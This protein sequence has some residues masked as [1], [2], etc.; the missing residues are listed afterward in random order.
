MEFDSNITNNIDTYENCI[1]KTCDISKELSEGEFIKILQELLS[2][3]QFKKMEELSLKFKKKYTKSPNPEYFLGLSYYE[4]GK[5]DEAISALKNSMSIHTNE[6]TLNNL[7]LAY[8]KSNKKIE[9]V[10]IFSKAFEI[11]PKLDSVV[12]NYCTALNQIDE[13]NKSYEII[14]DFLRENEENIFALEELYKSNYA[15]DEDFNFCFKNLEKLIINDPQNIKVLEV[16]AGILFKLKEYD[17]ALTYAFKLLD[18]EIKNPERYF[19]I[20]RIFKEK[21]KLTEARSYLTSAI[22][23][24]PNNAVNWHYLAMIEKSL[25]RL[26][27]AVECYKKSLIL[28]NKYADKSWTYNNLGNSYIK[29]GETTLAY[30]FYNKALESSEHRPNTQINII[31]NYLCNFSYMSDDIEEIY[32][33]HR[34]FMKKYDNVS[35]NFNEN[36]NFKTNNKI[37]I[38]YVSPDFKVHS[39]MFFFQQIMINHDRDKFEI[40]LYSNMHGKGDNFTE[41]FKKLSCHW[42]E[43]VQMEDDR[44]IELIQNDKINILVDL[45]GNFSGGRPNVFAHKPAPIQIS[46][47]GYVTTTGLKNMDYRFTTYNADPIFENDKYY[48]E[49]LIRL[50]ETFLC[51]SNNEVYSVQNPPKINTNTITFAS[52]NNISKIN[53]KTIRAWSAV[54]NNV[55]NSVLFIKSSVAA[56]DTVSE[57]LIEK[58]QVYG[59]NPNRIKYMLKTI[60]IEDH[61]KIYNMVDIALDTFPFNGATTT[62]EALWMGVPV[63][64]MEGKV[65]HSRVSTSVLKS[66]KMDY[67][68][69]QNQK[70]F[71]TKTVK[72]VNDL[73]KLKSL[74]RELRNKIKNSLLGNGE[75]FT[76]NIEIEYEKMFSK[77]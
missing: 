51:Y 68:I 38:G 24:D 34:K 63:M 37:R 19:H 25:G 12:L 43:T 60:H 74:R 32:N 73:E 9:A 1:D 26:Y 67:C 46:Y 3:K 52:F 2:K 57:K 31:Q 39:V 49:K 55:E 75:A 8:L 47:C 53:D 14:R 13:K 7:G 28:A 50:P 72:L 18:L 21:G 70:D 15:T 41:N 76:K 17:K 29:L 10:K 6:K 48:T 62:F 11:N 61:L 35:S 5:Y 42:R 64:T 45:A 59:V 77:L 27:H 54:L 66:L 56:D 71:V 33:T 69:G 40:F 23:L 36:Q 22:K 65:H 30:E 20:S 4:Q 44:L 16:T 58:F